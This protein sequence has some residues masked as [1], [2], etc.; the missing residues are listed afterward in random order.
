MIFTFQNF[1]QIFTLTHV[2]WKCLMA[3]SLKICKNVFK[4]AGVAL[5]QAQIEL[6]DIVEVDV[7]VVGG[8]SCVVG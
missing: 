5:A 8:W 4:Q 6:K 2:V 1:R 3:C 7:V